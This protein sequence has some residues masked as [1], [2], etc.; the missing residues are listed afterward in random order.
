M[1]ENDATAHSST[2]PPIDASLAARILA[3]FDQNVPGAVARGLSLDTRIQEE[4]GLPSI[5]VVAI[6][7]DLQDAFGVDLMGIEVQLGALQTVRD[8]AALVA[9]R[10]PGAAQAHG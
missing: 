7:F 9:G 4:L 8:V 5:T 6:L 2:Q 3:I 1:T 10:G